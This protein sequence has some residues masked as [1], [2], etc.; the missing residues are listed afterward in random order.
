MLCLKRFR[1]EGT[2]KFGSRVL[3]ERHIFHSE[4]FKDYSWFTLSRYNFNRAC[5]VIDKIA[6]W[7]NRGDKGTYLSTFSMSNWNEGKHISKEMKKAHSLSNCKALLPVKLKPTSHF[8]TQRN[9]HDSKG[10]T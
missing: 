1:R 10:Y 3:A 7:R 4:H 6:N 8:S 5:Q 9:V 2:A